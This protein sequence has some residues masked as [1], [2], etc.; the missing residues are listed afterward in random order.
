MWQLHRGMTPSIHG[1]RSE[2]RT[3]TVYKRKK[4]ARENKNLRS[5]CR[6]AAHPHRITIEHPPPPIG[7]PI[8][9]RAESLDAPR[10]LAAAGGAHPPAAATR[11]ANAASSASAAAAVPGSH[12]HRPVCIRSA[13]SPRARSHPPRRGARVGN[14][15]AG[16]GSIG[17][18][19]RRAHMLRRASAGCARHGVP[20]P[21][22]RQGGPAWPA[23]RAGTAG[24]RPPLGRR[25]LE[26][27]G[28]GRS[29]QREA[30]AAVLR[31]IRLAA[32]VVRS[33]G[34]VATISFVSLQAR[35]VIRISLTKGSG[36]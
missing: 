29:P 17:P 34:V 18:A 15:M 12:I 14:G 9:A 11:G 6:I 3:S 36:R 22:Q 33:C 30:A 23:R 25:R 13:E 1:R 20:A 26:L 10:L 28:N 24:R 27:G 7:N 21:V 16:A 32:P 5:T 4:H 19:A 31:G 2:V 8:D 35:G